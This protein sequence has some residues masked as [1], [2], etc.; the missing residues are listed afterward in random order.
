VPATLSIPDPN[1]DRLEG[2]VDSLE[3]LGLLGA[4]RHGHAHASLRQT[5][6]RDDSV[7]LIVEMQK[8][9]T[10]ELELRRPNLEQRGMGAKQVQKRGDPVE[11]RPFH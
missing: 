2:E 7:R 5:N 4:R 3:K 6:V 8:V 1:V 10:V 11:R 9:P